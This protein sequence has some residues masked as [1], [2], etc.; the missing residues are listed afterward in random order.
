VLEALFP[1]KDALQH[2]GDWFRETVTRKIKERSWKY[3]GIKGTTVDIV[4]DVINASAVEWV[5]EHLVSAWLY[6]F[7]L[8]DRI[9]S[10]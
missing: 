1:N 6:I 8:C 10:V 3:G 5:A 2:H 7:I 4:H 9:R